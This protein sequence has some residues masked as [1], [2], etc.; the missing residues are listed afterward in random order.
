ML[1]TWHRPGGVGDW[2]PQSNL[3]ATTSWMPHSPAGQLAAPPPLLQIGRDGEADTRTLRQSLR[4]GWCRPPAHLHWHSPGLGAAQSRSTRQWSC[5]PT[6]IPTPGRES[7]NGAACAGRVLATASGALG[8]RVAGATKPQRHSIGLRKTGPSIGVV[9]AWRFR[10]AAN[11]NRRRT[12]PDLAVR[13]RSTGRIAGWWGCSRRI[14]SQR[15]MG[16]RPDR[17]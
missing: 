4:S 12:G 17:A 7:E 15:R 10:H 5:F 16:A 1:I 8:L 3:A 11:T 6:K 13:A 14:G 2:T 9:S